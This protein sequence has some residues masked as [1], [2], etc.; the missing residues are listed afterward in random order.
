MVIVVDR[1]TG[2][3]IRREGELDVDFIARQLVDDF[4]AW[5]VQNGRGLCAIENDR[6]DNPRE[7]R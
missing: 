4:E 6:P 5:L 2:E 7:Q 3:V 1:K